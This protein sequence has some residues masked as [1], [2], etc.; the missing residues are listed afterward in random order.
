MRKLELLQSQMNS[1]V[2]SFSDLKKDEVIQLFNKL[3]AIKEEF[4]KLYKL[5]NGDFVYSIPDELLGEVKD[6]IVTWVDGYINAIED[7][8]ER[9]IASVYIRRAIEKEVLQYR[10]QQKWLRVNRQV[11][12]WKTGDIVKYEGDK[13]TF[14][15]GELYILPEGEIEFRSY[16]GESAI[17]G[18]ESISMICP[19]DNRFDVNN[20]ETIIDFPPFIPPGIPSKSPETEPEI[21][22]EG[23]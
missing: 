22:T 10:N 16:L 4:D 7:I 9:L 3:T 19:V 12:E 17:V 14:H 1:T 18:S 11:N 8:E 2:E 5:N 13:T 20:C 23:E 6:G 21:P 15:Q